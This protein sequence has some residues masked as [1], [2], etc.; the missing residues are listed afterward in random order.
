VLVLKTS[1]LCKCRSVVLHSNC[2]RVAIQ[3]SWN[4]CNVRFLQTQER[5]PDTDDVAWSAP[6]SLMKHSLVW[7]IT[8]LHNINHT[9][10]YSKHRLQIVSINCFVGFVKSCCQFVKG[11]E[12]PSECSLCTLSLYAVVVVRCRCCTLSLL[13]AVVVVRC[14]CCTLSLLYAVVS[15]VAVHSC[16]LQ[17]SELWMLSINLTG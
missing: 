5:L 7:I 12:T 15:T 4:T 3:L 1:E 11:E 2:V 9:L 10:V 14:R 13:Y 6:F 17:D 16:I 8:W